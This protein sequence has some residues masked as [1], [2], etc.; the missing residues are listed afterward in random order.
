MYQHIGGFLR[1][2]KEIENAWDYTEIDVMDMGGY[3][4]ARLMNMV[5]ASTVKTEL[6]KFYD[7]IRSDKK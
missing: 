6:R 7:N 2:S 4:P 5:L 1:P 3:F